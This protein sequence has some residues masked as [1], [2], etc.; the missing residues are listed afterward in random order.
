MKPPI[1]VIVRT[2]VLIVTWVNMLLA[3]KGWNPIP[4]T[5]EQVGQG[6]SVAAAAI[7]TI[8]AWWKN[9]SVTIAAR[10]GDE[11]TRSLKAKHRAGVEPASPV[12]T[13]NHDAL[14]GGSENI[15]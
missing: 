3:A 15:K 10:R 11:V 4:F 14:E 13:I 9:N 8:W 7:A 12:I 6:V 1:E 2:A 5:D